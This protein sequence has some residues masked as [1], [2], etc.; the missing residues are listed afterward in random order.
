MGNMVGRSRLFNARV[1]GGEFCRSLTH[2]IYKRVDYQDEKGEPTTYTALTHRQ[3]WPL[4]FSRRGGE[5]L[6][7]N[8]SWC[9]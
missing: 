9:A 5:Q 3:S 6:E 4:S 1:D 7:F 2:T 8:N